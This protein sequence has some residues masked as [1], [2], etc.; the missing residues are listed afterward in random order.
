MLRRRDNLELVYEDQDAKFYIE[1]E[2]VE[3]VARV[4]DVKGFLEE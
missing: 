3:G 2:V 1:L 4:G